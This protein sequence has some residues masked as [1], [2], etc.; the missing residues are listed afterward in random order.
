VAD[1][2]V[3]AAGGRLKHALDLG[4]DAELGVE[5]EGGG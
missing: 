3:P 2:L 5:P 4:E 1:P